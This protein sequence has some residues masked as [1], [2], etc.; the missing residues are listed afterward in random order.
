[1]ELSGERTR[2]KG[3]LTRSPAGGPRHSSEDRLVGRPSVAEGAGVDS[4]YRCNEALF[5]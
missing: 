1:M 5:L 4:V 2:L 3:S